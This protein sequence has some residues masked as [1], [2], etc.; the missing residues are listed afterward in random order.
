MVTTKTTVLQ[1]RPSGRRHMG[2]AA[3]NIRQ[4]NEIT[5]CLC[6]ACY[7]RHEVCSTLPSAPFAPSSVCLAPSAAHPLWRPG[8]QMQ[9]SRQCRYFW[10]SHGSNSQTLSLHLLIQILKRLLRFLFILSRLE[11]AAPSAVKRCCTFLKPLRSAPLVNMSNFSSAVLKQ[12]ATLAVSSNTASKV[13]PMYTPWS[14]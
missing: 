10:L 12:L 3:H 1:K 2:G 13:F 6:M 9:S 14:L 8:Q 5:E 7:S 11:A 4:K